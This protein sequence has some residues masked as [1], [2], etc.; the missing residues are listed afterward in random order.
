M[1][2]VGAVSQVGRGEGRGSGAGCTERGALWFGCERARA[3]CGGG[4]WRRGVA[5]GCMRD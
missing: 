1:L 5:A 3:G 2:G 4:M